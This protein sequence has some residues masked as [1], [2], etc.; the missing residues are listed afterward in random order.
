[1]QN[2]PE[3]FPIIEKLGGVQAAFELLQPGLKTAEAIY[4]WRRRK[5]IPGDAMRILMAAAEKRGIPYTANDF[6]IKRGARNGKG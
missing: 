3:T 2:S 5:S 4:M 1:M 6:E